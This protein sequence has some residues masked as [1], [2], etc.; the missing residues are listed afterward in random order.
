M[1]APSV[2]PKPRYDLNTFI[3]FSD[4]IKIG[5]KNGTLTKQ[6]IQCFHQALH[7]AQHGSSKPYV[8][9]RFYAY[10]QQ[11]REG[12]ISLH[13][14]YRLTA[15]LMQYASAL[16]ANALR[17][18]HLIQESWNPSD[19]WHPVLSRMF[20]L[21]HTPVKPFTAIDSY[22]LTRIMNTPEKLLVYLYDMFE[23]Y[24][25]SK[26]RHRS[27]GFCTLPCPEPGGD[28]L[29]GRRPSQEI[30]FHYQREKTPRMFAMTLTPLKDASPLSGYR[31]RLTAKWNTGADQPDAA[32]GIEELLIKSQTF[33]PMKSHLPLLAQREEEQ[34]TLFA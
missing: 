22:T 27:E 7:N 6:S 12:H 3:P 13:E 9:E 14:L 31:Y 19:G 4:L 33:G 10:I 21:A 8:A 1:K 23:Y 26:R 20:T 34:H 11:H 17:E 29:L 30:V 18:G 16:A 2:Q 25:K 5:L 15:G 24:T 32:F 28:I